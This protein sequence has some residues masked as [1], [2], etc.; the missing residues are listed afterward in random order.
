MR[1][2]IV[3][4]HPLYRKG[5]RVV[6]ENN[7]P[8]KVVGE[9]GDSFEAIDLIKQMQP[10]IVVMDIVMPNQRGL[11]VAKE[12]KKNFSQIKIVIL[13]GHSEQCY[14]EQTLRAGAMGFVY[15][16]AALDEILTAISAVAQDKP[17]LSPAVLQPVI[18][19]F[20]RSTT[21]QGAVASFN[22]LTKREQETLLLLG[23]GYKRRVVAENLGLK[24]KTVDRYKA[25]IKAKLGLSSD[26]EIRNFLRLAGLTNG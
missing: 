25:N 9:A 18:S 6:L 2:V 7:S 10:D 23:R 16:K 26:E 11:A 14:V 3:D 5:L 21:G 8:F 20:L 13:S 15:K 4:D 19:G 22:T 17:Y 1:I 12:I 24:P